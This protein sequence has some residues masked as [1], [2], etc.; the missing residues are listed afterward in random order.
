MSACVFASRAN[1]SANFGSSAT[2]RW[3]ISTARGELLSASSSAVRSASPRRKYEY[4]SKFH[5]EQVFRFGV[6]VV[7]PHGAAIAHPYQLDR[8][9]HSAC[10]RVRAIP[11]D[12]AVEQ[13]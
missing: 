7:S 13:V 8:D 3:N 2:A 4:A 11:S 5:V 9:S 1:A 12:A 6:V 10:C